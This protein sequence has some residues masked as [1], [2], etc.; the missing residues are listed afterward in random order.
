MSKT[1]DFGMGEAID[2]S[3]LS[4]FADTQSDEYQ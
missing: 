4:E 1:P 2:V 3:Q